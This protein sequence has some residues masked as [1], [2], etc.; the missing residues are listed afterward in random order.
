[1][2][3]TLLIALSLFV[4]SSCGP[5]FDPY[6]ELDGL[7]VLA[8]RSEPAELTEAQTARVDALI[9][10]ASKQPTRKSWSVC[11]WNGDPNDGYA[12]PVDQTTF[13]RAYAQAGLTGNPQRLSLGSEATVD[14]TFPGTREDAQKLCFALTE[15]LSS[16]PT[17]PPDCNTR[18]EWTVSLV[19][20]AAE[21][22]VST[23]KSVALLL[24]E[25]EEPNQNPSLTGFGIER[26]N[27]ELLALSSDRQL[28][29]EKGKDH[30][31]RAQ[32]AD[33]ASE[34]F[35]PRPIPGQAQP[36]A[37]L[38]ALTFTWFVDAG[39]TERVRS[40]YRDGVESLT[41]ASQTDWH[42]PDKAREVQ[43]FVVVRDQRGGVDFR[44]GRVRLVN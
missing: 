42:A 33:D 10:N 8:V 21:E 6:N 38:E 37:E 4:S 36:D 28:E 43:M 24:D 39:T 20:E 13:D 32:V 12:C 40:T 29:L 14:L 34:L 23:V 2:K 7:R 35:I 5:E 22:R 17:T 11:P 18:W 25:S 31:L 1:M 16:S 19:A 27:D 3:R 41:K 9:Y 15:L 44:E 30:A 26:A